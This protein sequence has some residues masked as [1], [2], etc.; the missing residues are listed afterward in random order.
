MRLRCLV[1]VV[2]VATPLAGCAITD[3]PTEIVRVG[4]LGERT[5]PVN[6]TMR[7]DVP[8]AVPGGRY[9]WDFGDNGTAFGASASHTYDVPGR[10]RVSAQEVV[11]E[12]GGG[13]AWTGVVYVNLP[14]SLEGAASTRLGPSEVEFPVHPNAT[15][16]ALDLKGGGVAGAEGRFV[17][18]APDGRPVVEQM[19]T[20]DA[21]GSIEAVL[22]TR[23]K[24]VPGTWL[25]V[26]EVSQGRLEWEA[27]GKV[28]YAPR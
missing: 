14:L 7:F 10:Y 15:R 11:A 25:L 28:D 21:T 6:E 24:P 17:L 26:I 9:F 8:G 16:V 20:V 23:A 18:A 13:E 1:A 5:V 19:F 12:Q 2:L 27:V 4:A 3:P 22:E